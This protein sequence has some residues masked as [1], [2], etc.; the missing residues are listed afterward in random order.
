MTMPLGLIPPLLD[1]IGING[2]CQSV[3]FFD[4]F[5]CIYILD[6]PIYWDFLSTLVFFFSFGYYMPMK[7]P[8]VV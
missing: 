2:P 6:V 5:T 4:V 1:F 7:R 8:P 3:Q